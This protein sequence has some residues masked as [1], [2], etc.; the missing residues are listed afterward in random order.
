MGSSSALCKLQRMAHDMEARFDSTVRQIAASSSNA[1]TS[2][3]P[4]ASIWRETYASI[5]QF[6]LEYEANSIARLE[7]Q[8]HE[9]HQALLAYSKDLI[10]AGE[11][12]RAIIEQLNLSFIHKQTAAAMAPTDIQLNQLTGRLGKLPPRLG[13]LYASS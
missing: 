4:L 11:T 2:S 7:V 6:D 13:Q 8:Y 12:G 10:Q 5:K 3:S 9:T 1:S